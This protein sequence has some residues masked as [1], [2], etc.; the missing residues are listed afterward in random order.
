[1]KRLGLLWL[2]VLSGFAGL[3]YELLWVRQL[4]LSLGS[5]TE[6]FATV[7]AVFFGGLALGSRWAGRRSRTTQR[8]VATYAALEA[9][10]G[11][12]GLVLL[13]LM[14]RLSLALVSLEPTSLVGATVFRALLSGLLLLPPTFLMGATLPF[15]CAAVIARDDDSGRGTALVY[16]LNTLGAVLGAYGVTYWLLPSL[17]VS[18]ATLVVVGLNLAVAA[19][20]FV[21]SRRPG[22]EGPA[23]PPTPEGTGPKHDTSGGKEGLALTL[24][25]FLMGFTATGA[26]LV[27]SRFFS[28]ALKGTA[29]GLGAV[30]VSVL[31]GIAL[32][33][34]L[35]TWL[36]RKPERTALS[37]GIAQ[38]VFILGLSLFGLSAG[39]VNYAELALLNLNK[40]SATQV[41]L[42]LLLVFAALLVPTVAA[43]MGL[44]LVVATA[45]R[46]A[47]EAGA[48]LAR[49]YSLN[50][51]GCILGSLLVGFV[52]LPELGTNQTLYVLVMVAT[53]ALAVFNLVVVPRRG[54]A[55]GLTFAA[56]ASVGL[57]PGFDAREFRVS[58]RMHDDPVTWL[59]KQTQAVERITF[60]SEGASSTVMVQRQADE[61]FTLSLNGLG[62][63]S[64]S[65]AAPRVLFESTLVAAVPVMHA[66]QSKQGLL[67]GLG[68][69]GTARQLLAMGVEHLEVLELEKGVPEAVDLMWGTASPLKDARLALVVND[70]RHHLVLNRA[71]GGAKYDFIASMPSHPWVSS[72]LF[73]SEFFELAADN[74]APGGV[75]STWF[76]PVGMSSVA[77]EGLFASFSAAFPHCVVYWVPEASAYYLVGSKAAL[78]L[79]LAKLTALVTGPA[80]ASEVPE[81]KTPYYLLARAVAANV[82]A[83][84]VLPGRRS[85]DDNGLL[86][87][88]LGQARVPAEEAMRFFQQRFVPLSNVTG[89]DDAALLELVEHELGNP[90]G[91]CPG[92]RWRG[93]W[94]ESPSWRARRRCWPTRSCGSPWGAG[95]STKR[96]A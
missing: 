77:I 42:E 63:G 8:P 36:A 55:A 93:R 45:G 86:E 33:S 18:G 56:L 89:A 25:A 65:P 48:V 60:F 11:V 37:S 84:P 41:H 79:D 50:T 53:L 61:S 92:C 20:A 47:R 87:F 96:G 38:L 85:T 29:Y 67:I 95:S 80:F 82:G 44:P 74:L 15:I 16:G 46:S 68:S 69:G 81:R 49:L 83:P 32:G 5:T 2:L 75:F 51:A 59:G 70:A 28:I 30:L 3:S 72:M 14:S 64:V 9:T 4:A 39:L 21:S 91:G 19:V 34:L 10:T 35:A 13:P 40:A 24:T 71:K 66:A 26:Q 62:Q 12:L 52:V 27:W 57:Y 7:L 78:T 31:S 58:E 54:L 6:S 94:R 88:N 1:V 22:G 76:G 23:A 43:G 73:T 90:V 17:G